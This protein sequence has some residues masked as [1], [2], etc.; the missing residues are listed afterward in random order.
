MEYSLYFFKVLV[1]LA[2]ILGLFYLAIKLV[3]EKNI[4]NKTNQIKVIE[5][6]YLETD[7]VLYLIQI[8]DQVWLVTSTKNKIEFVTELNLPN[9]IIDQSNKK[10]T[11][12]DILNKSK[13]GANEK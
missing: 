10:N 6:C 11:F 12:L 1:T 2:F 13:D 4:L 5:K 3:K 8:I 9:D 7:K